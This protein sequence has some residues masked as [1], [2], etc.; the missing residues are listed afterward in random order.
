MVCS[1]YDTPVFGTNALLQ[2]CASPGAAFGH[3]TP[4]PATGRPPG[5]SFHYESFIFATLHF[6]SRPDVRKYDT[7]IC[8]ANPSGFQEVKARLLKQPLKQPTGN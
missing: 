8:L 7:I 2:A 4:A 6:T 5:S 1:W 3:N